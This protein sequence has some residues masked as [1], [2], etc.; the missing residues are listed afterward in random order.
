MCIHIDTGL[1]RVTVD[2]FDIPLSTLDMSF[3]LQTKKL[4][5]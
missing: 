1:D 3:I 2:H 5:S 4:Q